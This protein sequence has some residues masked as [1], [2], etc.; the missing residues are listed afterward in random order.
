[1]TKPVTQQ[2]RTVKWRLYAQ[3]LAFP[4]LL[5]ALNLSAFFWVSSRYSDQPV[6]EQPVREGL[7]VSLPSALQR[8]AHSFDM[9]LHVA[10]SEAGS[11]QLIKQDQQNAEIV[12]PAETMH[13]SLRASLQLFSSNEMFPS[14]LSVTLA[15]ALDAEQDL[16][17]VAKRESVHVDEN[18]EAQYVV[19]LPFIDDTRYLSVSN[20]VSGEVASS[21]WRVV[22]RINFSVLRAEE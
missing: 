5:V 18:I 6:L 22:Q 11:V 3:T 13:L 2:E 7:S 8:A 20:S 1:M 14:E 12:M 16:Q 15:H 9:S 19:D 4:L 10:L 17:L 21:S